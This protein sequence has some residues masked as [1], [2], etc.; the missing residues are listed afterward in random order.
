[1]RVVLSF[2]LLAVIAYV[3][4]TSDENKEQTVV[5]DS[6]GVTV[7]DQPVIKTE[8]G[9]ILKVEDANN[10]FLLAKNNYRT[11]GKEYATY[12]LVTGMADEKPTGATKAA[13][14]GELDDEENP[15]MA[16]MT[17]VGYSQPRPETIVGNDRNWINLNIIDPASDSIGRTPAGVP[18]QTISL[19]SYIEHE[20]SDSVTI[21]APLAGDYLI[22]VYAEDD[23][24]D[25]AAYGIGIRIDGSL[26]S[27]IVDN[28]DLPMAQDTL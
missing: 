4:C 20:T 22:I 11:N 26:M 27:I 19:A 1:M 3:S 25:N 7:Y 17:I 15:I 18:F 9:K 2:L 12:T 13:R 23:A 16:P 28:K 5:Y 8:L 24:P 21:Q 14:P 6:Y 10:V